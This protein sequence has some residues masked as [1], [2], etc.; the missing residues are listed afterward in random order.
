MNTKTSIFD[1][2]VI[3][4]N[5]ASDDTIK[6]IHTN[7]AGHVSARDACK[8]AANVNVLMQSK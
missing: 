1:K 3:A 7:D 2:E 4:F 5:L 8:I 6:K